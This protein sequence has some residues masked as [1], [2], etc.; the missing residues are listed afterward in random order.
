MKTKSSWWAELVLLAILGAVVATGGCGHKSTQTA[1]S[2]NKKPNADLTEPADDS[3]SLSKS[4]DQVEAPMEASVMPV[5]YTH[6]GAD[7]TGYY[8]VPDGDGPFPAVVIIQ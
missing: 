8:S 3:G 4:T 1:N 6:D 7:L 5:N 2:T